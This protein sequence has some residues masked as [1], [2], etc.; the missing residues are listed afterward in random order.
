ML[1]F[2]GIPALIMLVIGALAYRGG[3]P[4][5]GGQRY[6][7]GRPYRVGPVWFLAAGDPDAAPAI[8]GRAEAIPAGTTG[9]A[10]DRW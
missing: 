9:G 2:V 1:V 5:G 4:A 3:K 6:R 10:S 7:P 8:A